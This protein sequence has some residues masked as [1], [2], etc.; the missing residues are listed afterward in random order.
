MLQEALVGADLSPISVADSLQR[1]ELVA[2]LSR[3]CNTG[4]IP[5]PITAFLS[6]SDHVPS[7]GGN[8]SQ[9]AVA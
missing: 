5:L 1:Y 7:C 2:C 3:L 9:L 4:R 8:L 6:Y